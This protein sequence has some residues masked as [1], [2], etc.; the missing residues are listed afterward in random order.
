LAI[1][2]TEFKVFAVRSRA[3]LGLALARSGQAAAGRKEC[4]QAVQLARELQNPLWLSEALLALSEAALAAGDANA[5]LASA[6]EAQARFT[7][8]KQNESAW[9][10]YAIQA[11]ANDKLANRENARQLAQQAESLLSS[12]EGLWGADNY[13]SYLAR[14]DI[15]ELR[16]LLTNLLG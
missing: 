10:A 8:A 12:L 16:R 5:A 15:T 9:R 1:A 14:P 4:E 7:A 13:K 3:T 6:T 2:G 11:L